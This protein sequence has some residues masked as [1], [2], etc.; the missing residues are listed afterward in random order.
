M[1]IDK[2]GILKMELAEILKSEKKFRYQLLSRIQMDCEYYLN[3]SKS[4][5]HLWAGNTKDQITFMK[6]IWNSFQDNEKP[7]W[8][9]LNEILEYEMKFSK[10]CP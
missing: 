4:E 6:A 10:Q 2:G 8:L 1:N 7:D 5:K 9:K 3:T